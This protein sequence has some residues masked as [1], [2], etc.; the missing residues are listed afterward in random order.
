MEFITPDIK[1]S[2]TALERMLT[3]LEL[4]VK[5]IDEETVSAG[6]S[7]LALSDAQ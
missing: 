4:K 3:D 5:K 6:E 7:L 2:H 1:K